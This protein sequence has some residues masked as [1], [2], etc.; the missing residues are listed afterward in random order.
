QRITSISAIVDPSEKLSV[1]KEDESD[2]RILECAIAAKADF[3][4]SGDRHLQ[5]LKE[6]RSIK[7]VSASE[8]LKLHRKRFI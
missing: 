8:F 1:I 7:I 5:A 4:I 3:V 6:S 2:N